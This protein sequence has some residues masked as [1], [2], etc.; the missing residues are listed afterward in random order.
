[1]CLRAC[2]NCNAYLLW[3]WIDSRCQKIKV[4]SISSW[5]CLGVFTALQSVD[6]TFSNIQRHKH[7]HTIIWH[8]VLSA[9]RTKAGP[10][11]G[12]SCTEARSKFWITERIELCNSNGIPLWDPESHCEAD[13]GA[14][15]EASESLVC[16]HRQTSTQGDCSALVPHTFQTFLILI[17]ILDVSCVWHWTVPSE[18]E[19]KD[20]NIKKV[21][22]NGKW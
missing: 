9:H 17:L 14:P 5:V 15:G 22:V 10:D 7:F 18:E 2:K 6:G 8:H 4:L 12:P 3:L 11:I 16:L 20:Y 13:W 19:E 1:M 21:L